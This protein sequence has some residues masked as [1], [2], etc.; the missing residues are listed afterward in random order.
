MTTFYDPDIA[1][2]TLRGVSFL[3]ILSKKVIVFHGWGNKLKTLPDLTD[4]IEE[5]YVQGNNLSSIPT[6]QKSYNLIRLSVVKNSLP[7]IPEKIKR[8]RAKG[9]TNNR[10]PKWLNYWELVK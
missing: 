7:C 4:K 8:I 3:P 1:S 9:I 6:F 2:L 5:M 10:Y